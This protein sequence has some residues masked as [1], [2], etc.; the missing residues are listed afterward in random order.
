VQLLVCDLHHLDDW[1]AGV[2]AQY[3]HVASSADR[4]NLSQRS[5]EERLRLRA[6]TIFLRPTMMP[7]CGPPNSLFR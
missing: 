4:I 6:S 5:T 1:N 2:A 7:A 3:V